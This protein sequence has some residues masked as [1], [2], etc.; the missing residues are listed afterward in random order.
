MNYLPLAH[1]RD[2]ETREKLYVVN[3]RVAYGLRKKGRAQD[4]YKVAPEEKRDRH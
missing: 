4:N 3:D 2:K 1:I